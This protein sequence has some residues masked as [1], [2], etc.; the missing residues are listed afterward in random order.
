M[1]KPNVLVVGAGAL[2]TTC[3]YFL[4]LAGAKISFLV[5]P[6]RVEQMGD[7]QRLFSYADHDVKLLNDYTLY[8]HSDQLKGEHFDY[9]LLTLDGATCLSEQGTATIRVLGE[10]FSDSQTQLIINGVGFELYEFIQKTTGFSSNQL[11]E[12][13][14]ASYAYQIDRPNTPLPQPS[15]RELHDSCDIAFYQFDQAGFMLAN[16]PRTSAK[17]FAK[18]MARSEK[19]SCR[20]VPR[21]LYRMFTSI[22]FSFSVGS[23]IDGWRGTPALVDNHELWSLVCE[24]QREIMRLKAFGLIGKLM[25]LITSDKKSA[26]R[27]LGVE[28]AAPLIDLNL[29]NQ[30][31]HG[32]KV[33][34]QDVQVLE[35]CIAVGS[36]EGDEM[37]ASKELIKRWQALQ[38]H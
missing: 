1:S 25:A 17:A 21:T 36:R 18:L 9:I 35:N 27:M 12:G 34:E 2:G 15:D 4:Q 11:L 22:F 26:E 32:G 23:E 5:R 37:N 13:T 3:A 20:S 28:A 31:H 29:F 6:H 30:F 7:S 8:D 19:M 38:T 14:L 33:L 16:N 10:L 24:S